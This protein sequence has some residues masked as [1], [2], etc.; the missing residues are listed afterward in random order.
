ME[1]KFWR[2]SSKGHNSDTNVRKIICYNPDH[3]LVDI[4]EYAKFGKS[5]SVY[6]QDNE[7]K[8]NYGGQKYSKALLFFK[9]GLY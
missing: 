7:Q 9:A 4:N 6:S 8:R 3:Y 5:L 1:T 2:K